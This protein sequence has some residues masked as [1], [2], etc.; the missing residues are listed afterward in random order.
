[1]GA[2]TIIITSV[3]LQDHDPSLLHLFASTPLANG[4]FSR[5]KISFPKR[6]EFFT[7]TGDL[8][9]SLILGYLDESR[10]LSDSLLDAAEKA[11][12]AIQSVLEKTISLSASRFEEYAFMTDE[13]A[14]KIRSLELCLVQSKS[15]IENPPRNFKG[16]LLSTTT[17]N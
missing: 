11:I 5:F 16:V 3:D 15:I 1:M 8:F 9:A 17:F 14:R 4:S 2:K 7:G 10:S 12:S 13:K 6:H